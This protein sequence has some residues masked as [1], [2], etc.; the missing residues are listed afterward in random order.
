MF[1]S[2]PQ[3]HSHVWKNIIVWIIYG[4]GNRHTRA[5][6]WIDCKHQAETAEHRTADKT[7]PRIKTKIAKKKKKIEQN[8]KIPKKTHRVVVVVFRILPISVGIIA[9]IG[10]QE[11]HKCTIWGD[12]E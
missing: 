7:G 12:Q 6:S 2:L 4:N 3:V 5:Q 10:V 1:Y 8:K 11:K 9:V